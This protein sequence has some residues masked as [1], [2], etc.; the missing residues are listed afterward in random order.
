MKQIPA[1]TLSLTSLLLHILALPSFFLC[2]I[3]LYQSEWMLDFLGMGRDMVVF[4]TLILMCIMI[5]IY[6]N[7]C[8]M[9]G[10]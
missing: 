8:S 5:G 9:L 3:L 4:N 2:F 10:F 1:E 6:C 7:F